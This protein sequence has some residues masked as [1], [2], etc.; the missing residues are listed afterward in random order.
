MLR[1][2]PVTAVC[3]IFTAFLL[4]INI[5]NAAQGETRTIT[6]EVMDTWC[7]T[8]QIMGGSDFVIGTSHHT[9]AVWCAA[10]G[11]PV[12]LLDNQ[13]GKIYMIMS[14]GDDDTSVANEKLL[15]IQ[16]HIITVAGRT[17][18]LDGINY[19]MIDDVIEDQ[20]ITNLTHEIIG[21]L[22]AE[23]NPQ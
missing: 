2:K 15:D 21:I 16:S 12:G 13:D 6:G 17:F 18:E 5:G 23:A 8:S 7:Y 19:I 14:V 1:S 9:C 11:I 4:S 20:G 3:G 22:P 10:G